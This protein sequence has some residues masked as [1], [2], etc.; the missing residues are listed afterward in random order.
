M[1]L[2]ICRAPATFAE[3]SH[4][5]SSHWEASMLMPRFNFLRH[6]LSLK[7]RRTDAVPSF[8]V[9]PSRVI[10]TVAIGCQLPQSF[11]TVSFSAD[12]PTFFGAFLVHFTATK[13]YFS[14]LFATRKG[15]FLS[16]VARDFTLKINAQNLLTC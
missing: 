15:F 11:A 8:F 16:R 12:A 13:G 14:I 6:C 2:L 9:R 7:R 5:L 3:T 4:L 10:L 1:R